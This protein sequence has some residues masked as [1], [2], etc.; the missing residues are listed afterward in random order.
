MIIGAEHLF[1]YLLA[2]RMSSLQKCLLRS[3]A[4]FLM[5]LFVCL[6]LFELNSL[7]ILDVNPLSDMSFANIFFHSV[8]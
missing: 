5:G 3:C 1:L 7:S 2:I 8:V 6:F 4:H